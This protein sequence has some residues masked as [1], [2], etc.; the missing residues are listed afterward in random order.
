MPSVDRALVFERQVEGPGT[1][2][3]LVGAGAYIYL[4][5]GEEENLDAAEGMEQLD[6]P[7]KS[8]RA[9]ADWFLD[10]FDNPDR[11]LASLALVISAEKAVRYSHEKATVKPHNLPRGS[12][13]EVRDAA[14]AWESRASSNRGNQV[15]FYFCGHGLFSGNSVLICR[16]FGKTMQTRFDGAVNFDGFLSAMSTMQPDNQLFLIDACRTPAA[17]EN[18]LIG[19]SSMG[20][21]LL[22]PVPL[23][24]RGGSTAKQSVHFAT[25]SLASSYGRDDG[26]SLYTDALLR[27][28]GGGGAQNDLGWWVGT[29]GLQTALSAYTT[30]IARKYDVEQE[31]DRT[32]SGQFK[33]HKPA[34]VEVPIYITCDPAD[35]WAESFRI[36]ARLG[37]AVSKAH[38]HDPASGACEE[39]E[40]PLQLASYELAACFDPASPFAGGTSTVM[41]V[42][43]EAPCRISVSRR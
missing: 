37:A 16:D 27:A 30:R 18:Y 33:V 3:L 32:R 15:I 36:E 38:A 23:Q 28:L 1:H 40:F 25:S 24:T 8:A 31:P 22:D 41:A 10:H 6:A 12:V 42:P 7:P 2:V 29:N 35:V 17:I 14:R 19:R 4:V 13:P 11:P 39:L 20:N 5:D 9:L 43:P 21:S 26:V 34:C